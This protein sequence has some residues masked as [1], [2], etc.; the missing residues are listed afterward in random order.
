MLPIAEEA[1]RK[2]KLYKLRYKC[3]RG[4]SRSLDVDLWPHKWKSWS[5][6]K[7]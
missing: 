4:L 1:T 2:A 7:P 5:K 3:I 6:S